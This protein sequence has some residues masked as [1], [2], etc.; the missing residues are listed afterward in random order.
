[1]VGISCKETNDSNNELILSFDEIPTNIQYENLSL[2]ETEW[3]LIGFVNAGKNTVKIAEP[4]HENCYRL[5]FNSDGTLSGET[6]TNLVGGK[7][8]VNMQDR[9]LK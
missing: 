4:Q 1:L 2:T 6:S 7:Y 5:T 3:K 8:E 9:R